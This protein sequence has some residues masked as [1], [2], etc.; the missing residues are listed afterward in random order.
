MRYRKLGS[1]GLETP[2]IGLGCMGMSDYYGPCEDAGSV[3]VIQ[4]A[5]AAGVRMLDTADAYGTGRNEELLGATVQGRRHEVLIATKF[6]VI[7]SADGRF[8]GVSGRPEYV[9]SACEASLRRL[10]V[11]TID[12]YYQHRLDPEVPIEDTIGAMADLVKTGKVRYLGMSECSAASL[13]R[14]AAVH[15]ITAVQSEYSL[16]SRDPETELLA[17]CE[18][19]G[20]SFVAYSPLG[21]GMLTGAFRSPDEL[22]RHD[23]RREHPR[24]SADNFAHNRGLVDHLEALA[25]ERGCTPAQ[26]A[27]AWLL[28]RSA[29]VIALPGTRNVARLHENLAAHDLQ[30]SADERAQL[31]ALFPH[32]AA[33]G[34]RYP[35]AGMSLI[36]ASKTR[37]SSRAR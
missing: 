19:L 14:A 7:R 31:D 2:C 32:G 15:P 3:E 1:S 20:V 18:Q 36:D 11:E 33:H 34:T 6:A 9:R 22:D 29:R 30:L 27:L 28:D 25:L 23:V 8:L 24:F 16:W 13:R 37:A 26:L 10:R 21:R 35:A 17:A 4:A 12:L 5:I